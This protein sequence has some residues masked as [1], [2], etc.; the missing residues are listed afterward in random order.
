MTADHF[1]IACL[2]AARA[3]EAA[4]L[5]SY[6]PDAIATSM[7]PDAVLLRIVL[8]DPELGIW[9]QMA[10]GDGPPTGD[11]RWDA[12]WA[13]RLE[14]CRRALDLLRA[15]GLFAVRQAVGQGNRVAVELSSYSYALFTAEQARAQADAYRA[16]AASRA[17]TI[18]H[19]A[20]ALAALRAELKVYQDM[21]GEDADDQL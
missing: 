19:Q 7:E 1:D 13:E 8:A 9:W 16:L 5:L 11:P 6:L 15:D 2:Q 10:D 4:M 17:Q 20:G 18:A 12:V 3:A 21:F 14:A